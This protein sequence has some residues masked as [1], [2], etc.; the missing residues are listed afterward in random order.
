MLARMNTLRNAVVFV[1]MLAFVSTVTVGQNPSAQSQQVAQE[2]LLDLR[3]FKSV[4]DGTTDNVSQFAEA[5]QACRKSCSLVIPP[6]TYALSHGIVI[7]GKS[8]VDI[9]AVGVTLLYTGTDPAARVLEIR[10]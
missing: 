2:S 1:L 5:L 4:A 10:S 7:E 8:H 6:G 3:N 9:H